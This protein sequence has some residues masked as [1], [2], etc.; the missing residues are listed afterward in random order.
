MMQMAEE[1]INGT[2]GGQPYIAVHMRIAS[3]H[4]SQWLFTTVMLFCFFT[5]QTLIKWHY[6]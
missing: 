2:M 4:V 6:C 3:D 5:V 1:F